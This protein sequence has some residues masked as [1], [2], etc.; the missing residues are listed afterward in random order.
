MSVG[1]SVNTLRGNLVGIGM[2][3]L[4]MEVFSFSRHGV[5]YM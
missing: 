4:R 2:L 1:V 3:A 5:D